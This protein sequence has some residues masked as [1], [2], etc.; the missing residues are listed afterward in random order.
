[1]FEAI[2]NIIEL[3]LDKSK[4]WTLKTGVFIS[5][6]GLFFILDFTFDWSY[7]CFI[8][9]KLDNLEKIQIIKQG[10]SADTLK[11]K[12]IVVLEDQILNKKH[13]TEFLYFSFNSLKNSITLNIIDQ[14]LNN[15]TTPKTDTNKPKIRSYFFMLLTSNFL[16]LIVFII[17]IFSPFFDKEL[18]S[19]KSLSSWFATLISF[20]AIIFTT[21]FLSFEIPLILNEPLYNYSLNFI[22]HILLIVIII[23]IFGKDGELTIYKS[24][25]HN[26]S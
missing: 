10:Y 1:M 23:K 13:Y 14:N 5:I 18:K 6:I 26:S 15:K 19:L 25:T 20:T 3:F 7:N 9:I 4:H 16:F 12:K 11:S 2:K 24:Q 22:L 21:T 17:L 8:N